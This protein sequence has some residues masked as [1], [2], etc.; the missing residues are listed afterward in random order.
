MTTEMMTLRA[1][2]GEKKLLDKQIARLVNSDFVTS[3]TNN[4]GVINGLS[5]MEWDSNVK[6]TLQSLNGKIKR[7]EAIANA[8]M[9]ANV[10]N[11]V[12]LPKFVSLLSVKKGEM[13][14]ISM[15][16]AIARKNYYQ[17]I[18]LELLE[19]L[20]DKVARAN[21]KYKELS[22]ECEKTVINRLNVEFAGVQNVS[23]KTKEEREKAIRE[24]IEPKYIDPCQLASKITAAREVIENYLATIDATLGTATEM[25]TVEISY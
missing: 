13:E 4:T 24:Q 3:I 14:E 22:K 11:K 20:D 7:R 21:K 23:T 10:K 15:A 19:N 8:I 1:A 16:S 9:D 6:A 2:L 5:I 17:F 18:L 12:S 25:T